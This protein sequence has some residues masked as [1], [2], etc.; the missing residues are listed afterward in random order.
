[1]LLDQLGLG[2]DVELVADN[3]QLIIRTAKSAREDWDAAF[4]QKSQ[5]GDDELLIADVIDHDWDDEQW[6]WQW[7]PKESHCNG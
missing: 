7:K 6:E 1:M 3:D 2:E 5:H 4:A